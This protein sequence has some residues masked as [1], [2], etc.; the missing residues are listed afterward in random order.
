MQRFHP[1]KPNGDEWKFK[2][3][4]NA[5]DEGRAVRDREKQS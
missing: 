5:R 3:I 1:D 2:Q 4:S